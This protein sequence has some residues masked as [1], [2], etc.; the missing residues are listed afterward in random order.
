M[1][2]TRR[3]YVNSSEKEGGAEII[4]KKDKKPKWLKKNLATENYSQ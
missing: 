1:M 3:D 4:L 2:S